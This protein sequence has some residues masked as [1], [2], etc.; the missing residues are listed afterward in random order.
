[1]DKMWYQLRSENRP[2][3]GECAGIEEPCKEKGSIGIGCKLNTVES[4]GCSKHSLLFFGS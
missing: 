2:T 3:L 4:N 1:M